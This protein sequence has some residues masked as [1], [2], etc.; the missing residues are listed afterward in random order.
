MLCNL[1]L[2]MELAVD[3]IQAHICRLDYESDFFMTR[4]VKIIGKR[5]NNE[6]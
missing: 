4:I 1:I 3:S 2:S 5:K 6:I